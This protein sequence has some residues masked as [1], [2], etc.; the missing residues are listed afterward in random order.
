MSNASAEV[1]SIVRGAITK[2]LEEMGEDID[3]ELA[4]YILLMIELS[5]FLGESSTQFCS[6]LFKILNRLSERRDEI[7]SLEDTSENVLY[8]KS[9]YEA[10]K[11]ITAKQKF[12]I[13]TLKKQILDLK[14]A[15]E[16]SLQDRRYVYASSSIYSESLRS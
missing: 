16:R 12:E 3:E 1:S 8:W 11:E 9:K 10:E 5:L 7:E 2:K 6:W 4:D 14:L 15:K 13:E